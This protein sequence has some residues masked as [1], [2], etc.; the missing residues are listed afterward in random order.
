MSRFF[1]TFIDLE[2]KTYDIDFAG[3]VSNIV[4]V[5][6]L[7]DLRMAMLA[8]HYPLQ[9]QI[10][11]DFA[12]AI[13]QTKVDYKKPLKLFDKVSG[14]IWVTDI[15]KIRWVL[16]FEIYTQNEISA[17]AEQTGI[18]FSLSRNRPFPIPDDLSK[19]YL[20]FK[21]LNLSLT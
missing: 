14:K 17:L 11:R 3:V 10:E 18:F 2:V 5:R 16:Q 4:Y 13:I 9:N 20:E 8:T 15:Q 21:Q 6:W 12:P 1:E 19:K 7:E